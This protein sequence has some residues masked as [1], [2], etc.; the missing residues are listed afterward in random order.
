LKWYTSLHT[1][2]GREEAQS[3]LVEGHRAIRQ[4]ERAANHRIREIIYSEGMEEIPALARPFRRVTS[5]QFRSICLS[6]HPA[7][8]LA[9]VS[10]PDD[11]TS[12]EL[13]KECGNKILVLE[14]IQ[15]PGNAGTL[16]RSASAFDFSG[17][18]CS[19]KCADLFSPKAVQAS[20]GA[21]ISMWLRRTPAYRAIMRSLKS[22]GFRIVA[23]DVRGEL[24]MEFSKE[25]NLALVLGNE[26]AGISPDTLSIA[27]DVVRIPF[28]DQRV[29]SLNVAAS[30]AILMYLTGCLPKRQTAG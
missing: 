28:N 22:R 2:K 15:D 10:M 8:P 26:G 18:V 23:A 12:A 7:G 4:I 29:E 16:V 14:D 5:A 20:C 13:P 30:G 17:I 24:K 6:Q 9:V 11:C 21:L 19:D 1:S 27:H 25:K 3:F